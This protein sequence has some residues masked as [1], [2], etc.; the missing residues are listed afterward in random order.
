MKQRQSNA[1]VLNRVQGRTRKQIPD[2]GE[3][4]RHRLRLAYFE[5]TRAL[6]AAVEAKDPH[7]RRHSLTVAYYATAIGRRIHLPA[8]TIESL[9][10]AALLHD[11]GKI[12]VPDAILTKPGPLNDEE[13][14][15]VKRH[16]RTG[17]EILDHISSLSDEKP[18]ILH[19]HERYDG[20]GYPDGLAGKK[21]PIGARILAV[22]DAVDAMLSPRSY[23]QPYSIDRVR[24]ELLIASGR[25]FDPGVVQ[26]T[27][28]WMDENP[29][30][31]QRQQADKPVETV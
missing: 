15:L 4:L 8:R 9:W 2:S 17:L 21:I 22:A 25:Q 19:H 23:K 6:V 30:A 31:L 24:K 10:A 5:S 11:V 13:F 12:G 28:R 1:Q 26:V 20:T 16:P 14:T 18:M 27:L 7:T 3:G 29:Q